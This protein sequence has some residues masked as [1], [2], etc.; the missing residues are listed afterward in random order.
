MT[1]RLFVTVHT[2]Y[3][4]YP[5]LQAVSRPDPAVLSQADVLERGSFVG[6]TSVLMVPCT[7]KRL[8]LP[9]AQERSCCINKLPMLE[10]RGKNMART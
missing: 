4:H 6:K 7:D 1:H 2:L 10:L 5:P 3:I 8:L 9:P